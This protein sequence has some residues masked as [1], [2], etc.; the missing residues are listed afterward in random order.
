MSTPQLIR[1]LQ[2][3]ETGPSGV[4][5]HAHLAVA[6]QVAPVAETRS[7]ESYRGH[8]GSCPGVA[9]FACSVF[10]FAHPQ[11][12]TAEALATIGQLWPRQGEP[13]PQ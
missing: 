10:D 1:F 5:H 7:L 8:E 12:L 6:D 3:L 13:V 9:G 11:D 4:D 2:V